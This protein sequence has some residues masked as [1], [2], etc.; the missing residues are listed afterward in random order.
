M[1]TINCVRYSQT[2]MPVSN[3]SSVRVFTEVARWRLAYR[4]FV[5]LEQS[6][7]IG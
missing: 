2:A 3:L 5:A 7:L 1:M 6:W 4:V